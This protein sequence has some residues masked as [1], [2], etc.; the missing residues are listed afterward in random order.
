[1]PSVTQFNQNLFS[2]FTKTSNVLW[3]YSWMTGEKADTIGDRDAD[4]LFQ[5]PCRD[6]KVMFILPYPFW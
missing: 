2:I 3:A 5:E 6:Q 4:Y 1:M